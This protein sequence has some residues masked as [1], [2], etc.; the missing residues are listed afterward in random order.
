MSFATATLAIC[1]PPKLILRIG[2]SQPQNPLGSLAHF[3]C[4]GVAKGSRIDPLLLQK[5]KA[6]TQKCVSAFFG[7]ESEMKIE[8]KKQL[9]K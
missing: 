4:N 5:K 7:G 6:E 8:L 9:K 2:E 3:I 1:E